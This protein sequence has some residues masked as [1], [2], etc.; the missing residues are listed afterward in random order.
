MRKSLKWLAAI[1]LPPGLL[2][3]LA[4]LLWHPPSLEAQLTAQIARLT[5]LQAIAHGPVHFRLLPRPQ[6]VVKNISIA[7]SASAVR[8]AAGG[9]T[10]KGNLRLLALLA[11]TIEFDRIELVKPQIVVDLDRDILEGTSRLRQLVE[12]ARPGAG[13]SDGDSLG[14]FAMTGGMVRLTSARRALDVVLEDID[15]RFDWPHIGSP[16]AINGRGR[17]REARVNLALWLGT[18]AQ[19]LRGEQSALTVT[20]RGAQARLSLRGNAHG[21]PAARFDG[22]LQAEM[23]ALSPVLR[24]AGLN[25]SLKPAEDPFAVSGYLA[26]SL[27]DIAVTGLQLSFLGSDFDGALSFR[28]ENGARG[29]SGTLA[30]DLWQVSPLLN[31]LRATTGPD[32]HWRSQALDLAFQPG[33]QLDL[34]VSAARL[35]TGPF[36]AEDAALAIRSQRG[37]LDMELAEARI[38]GGTVKGH[39]SLFRTGDEL[40]AGL[41]GEGSHLDLAQIC[42]STSCARKLTGQADLSLV[43][44]GRGI[45][46]VMLIHNAQGRAQASL[47]NGS[48]DGIDFA[49]ALRRIEKKSWPA[50]AS[51]R[52]GTSGFERGDFALVLQNGVATLENTALTGPALRLDLSGSA[53]LANGQLA[54][55]GLASQP[56]AD[57]SPRQDGPK[58][59]F[60]L[61]GPWSSPVF[62]PDFR[63]LAPAAGE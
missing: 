47:A 20:L 59:P 30:T 12:P 57:G 40:T 4:T 28:D 26:A 39:A 48:F 2:V 10:L 54:L 34:R 22:K 11:G 52:E 14:L 51:L 60:E 5:G 49:Q 55:K 37:Q 16:L 19:L 17:W 1:L 27:R 63:N 41:E 36:H 7:D 6:I 23:P 50:L 8:I 3:V 56:E 31:W 18:P 24:L 42:A 29:L 15:I 53:A 61:S 33:L 58:L 21:G 46:P 38:F 25:A 45:S 13:G 44:A 9:A 35:T 32:G 43:L 62:T